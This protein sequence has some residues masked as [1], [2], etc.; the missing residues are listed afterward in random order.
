MER[1]DVCFQRSVFLF[2]GTKIW[3]W[4]TAICDGLV[5]VTESKTVPIKLDTVPEMSCIRS[6]P[7]A[8]H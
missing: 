7:N 8:L 3:C 5:S 6:P 2:F 1:V 4:T